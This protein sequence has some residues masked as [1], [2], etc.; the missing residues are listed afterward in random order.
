MNCLDY[1]RRLGSEPREDAPMREHRSACPRCAEHFQ[2]S[3]AFEQSLREALQVTVPEDLA[4]AILLRQTTARR[5]RMPGLPGWLALAASTVIAVGLAFALWPRGVPESDDLVARLAMDHYLHEPYAF[6]PRPPVPAPLL[7]SSGARAGIDL[8]RAPEAVSYAAVC[9]MGPYRSLHLVV[10]RD[11]A[12]VTLFVVPG[13]E[14]PA[15]HFERDGIHS[16]AMPLTG[17]TLLVMAER[18]DLLDPVAQAWATALSPRA[19][20]AAGTH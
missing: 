8:A 2:R 10:W 9:P 7:R 15:R 11:E 3:Q 18:A 6:D 12:P 14:T 20:V 1:R 17:G 5:R 19:E 16:R 4:E 13:M